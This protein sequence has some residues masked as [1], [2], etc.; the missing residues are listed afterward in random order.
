MIHMCPN[1]TRGPPR[2]EEHNRCALTRV[3]P[4]FEQFAN[5]A[6]DEVE[7]EWAGDVVGSCE[8]VRELPRM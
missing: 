4:G 3:A 8:A 7:R 6:V 5:R 1:V 2:P